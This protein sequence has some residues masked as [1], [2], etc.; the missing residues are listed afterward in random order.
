VAAACAALLFGAAEALES[1]LQAA[2][3]AVPSALL[4]TLPYVLA[5]AALATA[6]GRSRPPDALGS[7]G[8]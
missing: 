2:G 6:V 4:R 8:G 5:M 7:R 3:V 1:A